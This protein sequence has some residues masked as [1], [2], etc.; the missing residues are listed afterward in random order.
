MLMVRKT[1]QK[2]FAYIT[3]QNCLLVFRHVDVPEAGIQVPA[4]TIKAN[5]HPEQA[6]LREAVEETGLTDLT[7]GRFLGEQERD[8]SDCGR[9]EIHQRYFYHLHCNGVPPSTWYHEECD[10]SDGSEGAPIIFEF[11][12]VVLPYGVP[13]LIADHGTRLPQLCDVLQLET[14]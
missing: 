12:W 3:H 6:V 1:R 2:A 4:G 10:P 14:M 13:S 8:M 7:V 5:E 11:F 9:D